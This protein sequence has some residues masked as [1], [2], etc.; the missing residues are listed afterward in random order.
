MKARPRLAW[1]ALGGVLVAL[2]WFRWP[3]VGEADVGTAPPRPELAGLPAVLGERIAAAELLVRRPRT[4]QEGMAELGR[5]YQ[6]NGFLREAETCWRWL[7]DAQPTEARWPYLLAMARDT[8]GETDGLEEGLRATTR[9]APDY[10]PAWL[11]LAEL[12]LK[13]GRPA[14]AEAHYRTRL[15]LLPGDPHAQLGLARVA[16]QAGRP[17]EAERLLEELVRTSP[18][19]STGHNLLAEMRAARGDAAG[20]RWHRWRG[21]ETGRFAEADDPWVQELDAW[22]LDPRR[23]ARL[24]TQEFQLGRGD[25]G[26]GLL[27]RAVRLAPADPAGYQ[28]LGELQLKLGEFAP[29]LATLR[30]GLRLAAAVAGPVPASF[31]ANLAEA[32]RGLGRGEEALDVLADGLRR[33]GDVFELEMAR[34]VVLDDLQRPAEAAAAFRA[35]LAR[36]PRDA[37]ARFNLGAALLQLHEPD[38]A[39]AE[40][41]RALEGQPTHPL[42][43]ALLGQMALERGELAAAGRYL[44]P[45]FEAHPGQPEARTLLA[46]W[47]LRSGMAAMARHDPAE[48]ERHYRAGAEANPDEPA[49]AA[50]LGVLLL[51]QGRLAEALPPLEAYH[52]LAPTD[53]Q[54]WLFLGQAYALAARREDARRLLTEGERLAREAGNTVTAENCRAVL[55]RL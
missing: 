17:A 16:R 23:L 32:L 20:A 38:A 46:L 5:L 37:G 40:L 43:L 52:R 48:A 2:A 35:A 8:A 27:E 14:E 30:T 18:G 19:F 24:G 31:H 1:L 11:K 9:L 47:R 54:S 34:G 41:Q 42:A 6:A 29:A 33:G 15:R 3:A 44:E 28:L 12:A 49:L 50:S 10:A 53:P 22:C 45:L 13:T 55:D 36:Q 21:R 4:R 25:R 7:A 26:R 39:A 51:G